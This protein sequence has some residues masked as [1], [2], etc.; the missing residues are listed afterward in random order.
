[1]IERSFSPARLAL[2]LTLAAALFVPLSAWAAEAT[3]DATPEGAAAEAGGGLEEIVVTARKTAEPL[4][5]TPVAVTALSSAAILQQQMTQV[6]DL[7]RA[8][9]DV[10]VT[11][12]GPGGNANSYV[13]IRGQA[14][15]E[16]NSVSDSAV[17][18]YVDGVYYARPVVGNLGFLDVA[19]IEIL[20]GPQG[21][22][23]GRNTTGGALNVASVQPGDKLEGNVLAGFGNYSS[24]QF[25]G[26]VTIPIMGD[27]LS[28][29]IAARYGDHGAYFPNPI[30]GGVDAQELNHDVS[31]RATVRWAPSFIPLT[32]TVAGDL[33]RERDTGVPS[34][35]QAYNTGT[36]DAIGSAVVPSLTQLIPVA[37][38]FNPVNYLQNSA[39]FYRFYGRSGTSDPEL[40]VPFG[41]NNA[42]GVG[43]TLESDLGPLH[44][45]SITGYRQSDYRNAEDLDGTPVRF[46]SFLSQYKQHQVSEELQLSGKVDRFDL[47]GGLFYFRE[48]GTERSDSEALGVID[49]ILN[50]VVPAAA[51][52]PGGFQ[53]PISRDFSEYSSE[54]KAV[55]F[56][57]N[58]HIT[59][60]VRAT[61][62][63]R[64]TWDIRDLTREGRVDILGT[65]LCNVGATTGNPAGAPC[66]DPHSASWTYPAYVVSLDWQAMNNLFLYVKTSKASMAGGFNT[67]PVPPTASISYAP[68]SNRD[69]EI[70]VKSDA[71]DKHLRTN[72]ALFHSWQSGTQNIISAAIDGRSTQYTTN[73]GKSKKYGVELEVT[74]LPLDNTEV[75]LSGAY[76]HAAY[77]PGTYFETQAVPG[78]P[79]PVTVDRSG[80]PVPLAPKFTAMA[81]VTQSVPFD[82]GKLAL[83]ADFSYKD[84]VYYSYETPA[85]GQPD[86][87]AWVTANQLRAVAG[88]GLLS[89]RA[90]FTLNQPDVE[91]AIWGRNLADKH[92]NLYEFNVYESLGISTN[93]PGDPRT[94]GATINYRF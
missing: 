30:P 33:T 46:L 74:A 79:L 19:S 3:P 92:F 4:Q 10:A 31:G 55:F 41:E 40:N 39:N 21:T 76:L 32:L 56:Q 51:Q 89:A 7:Q 29:R 81:G 72:L 83:H 69:V 65:N 34:S 52:P 93:Y 1:M 13:S 71:F 37:T 47:I 23:F 66:S 64:Q 43:V 87:Q 90:S 2:T 57:T 9:P 75:Q 25:E 62:G 82:V 16:A 14:K 38:G 6:L 44:V 61:V 50:F 12:S 78:T 17:A 67:R 18:T 68:E 42:Q 85:A 45:K 73:A 20:R 49:D 86:Y 27:E 60:T 91:I 58:Y 26:A 28:T 59:D 70:G 84:K 15:E 48:A 11:T 63:Y 94:F 53:A 80:E 35:L 54:S 5:T 88:Y 8:A 24:K 77:V 36:L 22:L